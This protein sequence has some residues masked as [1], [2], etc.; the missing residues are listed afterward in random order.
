MKFY[1]NVQEKYREASLQ[2]GFVAGDLT[3]DEFG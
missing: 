1:R 3:E 2:K